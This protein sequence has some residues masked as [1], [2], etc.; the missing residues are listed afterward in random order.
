MIFI[1]FLE[2]YSFDNLMEKIKKYIENNKDFL[3]LKEF[4][5]LTSKKNPLL[6][7]FILDEMIDE[8]LLIIDESDIELRYYKNKFIG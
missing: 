4:S 7:K 6:S 3:S 8:G 2:D 5:E 1:N